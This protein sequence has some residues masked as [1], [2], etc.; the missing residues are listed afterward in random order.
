MALS[1]RH[2]TYAPLF[3]TLVF[4]TLIAIRHAMQWT[5]ARNLAAAVLCLLAAAG[6]ATLPDTAAL[7]ERHAGQAARFENARGPVSAQKNAAILAELKRKSSDIDILEKQIALEQAIVGSPLLLGNKVTLLQDGAA[8][9]PAMFA[10]IRNA[11]DHINLETYIIEDDEIGRQ[12]ADLLLEQQSRGVQVNI[13]YDSV[14]GFNTPKAFF[15]R[16]KAGGI[17]VL[18]FN[19]INPLKAKTPW[20]INNRDHRKLLVVD[21]R[22]AFIGGINISSV[23]SAGSVGRRTEK[24][25]GNPVAW[26]DTHLQIEGPVVGELQKLFMETWEKQRGQPLAP[27]EYFPALEAQGNE[28]VRAIGS[29]PDDPYS[30]I[31]LTL[32]SAIGNAEKQV[33]LT[34]AYFVPDPQLL[35]ALIDAA[36]R[37][38]DVRLLLPSHS[39]SAVVFHAGRSHYSGLLEGGV[40]LYERFG[41]LLHSKTAV[42]DG[43]WSTVG[44]TNLDW[45][46]FLDNDEVNAVILG[47]EFGQKM[48]AAFARDLEAS[49][50]IDLAS[51]ERRPL[52]FRFK[53]WMARMW[54]RLL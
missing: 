19:P 6:C 7:I 45:R 48:Q 35:K 37:G 9:Y 18:E 41:A 13:I 33:Y 11:R 10:A 46:S 8:T 14:G 39:D 44:S 38:V 49:E 5:A 32:I 2:R 47:R 16:L 24:A 51:W 1:V 40:K 31:Y 4:H 30:L 15:N 27:K 54:E 20:L 52:S 34:N 17:E 42:I 43:V 23:N 29:T 36:G 28:I 12:F 3:L 21:G 53:E 22:T 25:A 26:R 50:A